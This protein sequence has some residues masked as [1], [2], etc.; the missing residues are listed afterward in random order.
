M[1]LKR[2]LTIAYGLGVALCA[3]IFALTD[4]LAIRLISVFAAL[5]YGIAL[6]FIYKKTK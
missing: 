1:E 6:Y 3:I 2:T 5:I 4:R